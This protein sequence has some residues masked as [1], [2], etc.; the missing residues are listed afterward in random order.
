MKFKSKSK[1]DTGIPTAS[2]PDIV[3]MLLIFFMVTT[4]FKESEGLNIVLPAA[5]KIEKLPG[6]RDVAVIWADRSGRVSIN[7]RIIQVEQIE[8]IIRGKARD[9]LHPM[10]L[11]SFK[12][13]YQVEMAKV[14]AIQ[15]EL[16]DV[17]STALNINYSAKT[18][19]N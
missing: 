3:F 10:K 14:T 7:D 4:V 18:A 6:R 2:M 5:L 11:V 15:E 19:A 1:A 9:E 12:I 17:G 13:D 16:R 8:N